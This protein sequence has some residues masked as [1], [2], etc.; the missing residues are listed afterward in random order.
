MTLSPEKLLFLLVA[1]L[2]SPRDSVRGH[3]NQYFIK[4]SGYFHIIYLRAR[5]SCAKVS[6]LQT[7]H[8]PESFSFR[9]SVPNA[10]A[11]FDQRS[12]PRIVNHLKFKAELSFNKLRLFHLHAFFSASA[13]SNSRELAKWYSHLCRP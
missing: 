12:T 2:C 7:F 4:T 5:L 8:F 1:I 9:A 10:D 11:L 3:L 6:E 13:F